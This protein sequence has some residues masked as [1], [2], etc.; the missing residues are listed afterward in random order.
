M[1]AKVGTIDRLIRIVA[2]VALIVLA[3]LG[4]LAFG[5]ILASCRWQP[6]VPV[7]SSLSPHRIDDLSTG[8][9]KTY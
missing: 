2:G 7:L 6:A 9:E 3:A 5:A 4:R 1:T 8:V